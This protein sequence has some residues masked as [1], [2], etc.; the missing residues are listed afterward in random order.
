[1]VGQTFGKWTVLNRDGS[2]GSG[3]LTWL[4]KCT[5]GK[6]K[7]VSGTALRTGRSTSCGCQRGMHPRQKNLKSSYWSTMICNAKSRGHQVSIDIQYASALLEQQN[8]LC[9][10]TGLPISTEGYGE[11]SQT[12]SLDRIDSTVGYCEGNVQWVHKHINLMKNTFDQK[13]FVEMCKS[14]AKN[15]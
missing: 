12:A 10:L 9:A 6:V 7:S 5:C 4:C 15:N 14:V 3:N 1:M 8:Y 2:N 13:Y 11:H